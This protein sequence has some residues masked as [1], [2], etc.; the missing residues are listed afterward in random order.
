MR[1]EIFQRKVRNIQLFMRPRVVCIDLEVLQNSNESDRILVC[2]DLLE[3]NIQLNTD[4]RTFLDKLKDNACDLCL[5]SGGGDR[6]Q[7]V[8]DLY[9]LSRW[10]SSDNINVSFNYNEE[11]YCHFMEKFP[12]CK[13]YFIA[14]VKRDFQIPNQLGWTTCGLVDV[15]DD[16]A[17]F[18][19]SDRDDLS[20]CKCNAYSLWQLRDFVVPQ[21][22]EFIVPILINA[23]E[24]STQVGTG[25]ILDQYIITAAHVFYNLNIGE[26]RCEELK[27]KFDDR[28]FSIQLREALFDGHK[29][30]SRK[31]FS[32]DLLV[33]R[34]NHKGSPFVLNTRGLKDDM[35]F[36]SRAYCC[37]GDKMR[38]QSFNNVTLTGENS[39]NI[40]CFK[41]S[42]GSG[43]LFKEG[44]SGCPLYNGDVVYGIL[45][46]SIE[47]AS[48]Q[49]DK[50][51][52]FVD[53]RY[54]SEILQ[55]LA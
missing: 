34:V 2:S 48:A 51:F 43:F 22:T 47:H 35:I 29:C 17:L 18:G 7:Q 9:G 21:K 55:M 16:E 15:T 38:S 3:E 11:G 26:N 23:D 13:Y 30:E 5:V 32:Q 40:N 8:V 19:S 14:D 37:D 50:L 31:G 24:E 6:I 25:F 53:A 33:F 44:N 54:I 12:G 20:R 49:Y 45:W 4:S 39:D 1:N 46:K 27:Y 28:E 52:E 36:E 10:F 42:G 41:V